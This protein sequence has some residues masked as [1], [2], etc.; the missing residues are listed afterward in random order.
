M[1]QEGG[2]TAAPLDPDAAMCAQAKCQRNVRITLKD[3]LGATFDRTFKV[4]PA[5]VQPIGFVVLAG[6]T[7]LIEAD[8]VDGKLVN[9]VAVDHMTNPAKTISARFEQ[10]DGKGMMLTTNNPFRQWLKFSMSIMPLDRAELLKTSSCPIGPGISTFEMWPAPIFQ[11]ILSRG[12]L[13]GADG[14]MACAN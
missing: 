10:I 5:T 6:Q 8:V 11:V 14:E 9:L 12:H 13:F 4:L 3:K 7:V 2:G 1:A